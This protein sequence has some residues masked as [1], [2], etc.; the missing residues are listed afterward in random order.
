M[1]ERNNRLF[2]QK[3]VP[4]KTSVFAPPVEMKGRGGEVWDELSERGEES[5]R[6]T[7]RVTDRAGRPE[8]G[9]GKSWTGKPAVCGQVCLFLPQG[10][11]FLPRTVPDEYYRWTL[12]HIRREFIARHVQGSPIRW[13]PSGNTKE[14]PV[15]GARTDLPME[16][17]PGTPGEAAGGLAHQRITPIRVP[18]GCDAILPAPWCRGIASSG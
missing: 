10:V 5:G 14:H 18:G 3:I 13:M 15:A 11:R 4:E 7:P 8:G 9:S 6:S 2:S 1:R 17:I 12:H 16:K